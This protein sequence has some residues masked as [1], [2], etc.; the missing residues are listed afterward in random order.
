M[1]SLSPELL[2]PPLKEVATPDYSVPCKLH[3]NE[4]ETLCRRQKLHCKEL[5]VSKA[6]IND[7]EVEFL[8]DYKKT[9]VRLRYDKPVTAFCYLGLDSLAIK[10]PGKVFEERK[11][12]IWL[13]PFVPGFKH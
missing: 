8:C 5:G 12:N 13:P 11:L 9:K 4:L 7:Y 2:P 6:N 10:M 1:Y 3:W